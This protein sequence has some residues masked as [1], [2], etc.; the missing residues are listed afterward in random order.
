M[1]P[2]MIFGP[3]GEGNVQPLENEED[4]VEILK[5]SMVNEPVAEVATIMTSAL[6]GND[7]KILFSA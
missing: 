1:I 4:D 2:C 6:Q 3:S 7:H 5:T